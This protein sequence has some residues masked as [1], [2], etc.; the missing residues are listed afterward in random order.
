MS[1]SGSAPLSPQQQTSLLS[2]KGNALCAECSTSNPS[3]CSLTYGI[4]LCLDCAGVH[5]GLGVHLSFVRSITMDD[6]NSDQYNQMLRGGND[7]WDEAWK[8][9]NATAQFREKQAWKAVRDGEKWR[10]EMREVVK[11]KYESEVAALY[12]DMLARKDGAVTTMTGSLGSPQV[13]TV[14]LAMEQPPTLRECQAVLF[15][16]FLALMT[17]EPKNL[18]S[19]I[20]WTICGFALSSWINIHGPVA[21]T[22]ILVPSILGITGFVPYYFVN[23]MSTKYAFVWVNHRHD[24]FKSAKNMLVDLIT[25]K[26]A[27]RLETCDVYYPVTKERKAKV[28]L[29]FYPGALVDRTAYAPIAA[30][31]A[32]AGIFV[33]VANLEPFRLVCSLKTYNSKEK[34]MRMIS[35]SLLLGAE[36]GSGLWEVEN[37]AIGGHSMGG[38]LAIASC[39]NEMSSTLKKVVLWGVGSYPHQLMHPCKPLR[40]VTSD[41]DV[42]LVNGSNDAVINAFGGKPAW[43]DMEA[44]LPPRADGSVKPGQGCTIYKTIQGGNHSGCAHYGPQM[45]PVRD[46][47]RSITLEQQQE[48]TAKL[49][50]DFLLG[51]YDKLSI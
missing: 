22:G 21:Y 29:V 36:D 19:L 51:E 45:Y 46:G 39:V 9:G 37:W 34:V 13:E 10:A 6:W 31:L 16:F 44:K 50:V 2:I 48:H 15:P 17:H 42:L 33:V 27:K 35:D 20:M 30:R 40:D 41:V 38:S 47:D 28:G 12:R 49:S 14:S 8:Q 43:D 23:S 4:T 25:N 26:R 32:E 5:R 18:M 24:A 7:K 3:W 1:K 11:S